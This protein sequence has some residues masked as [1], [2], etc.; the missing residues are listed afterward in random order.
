MELASRQPT[1]PAHRRA[2][3]VFW[4]AWAV[5]LL[6]KLQ[7]ATLDGTIDV[8][9][10]AEW[11]AT[12]ARAGFSA[13]YNS[14]ELYTIT[15][16]AAGYA[17]M[18]HALAGP[19]GIAFGFLLRLPGILAEALFGIVLWRR[20]ASCGGL[21][22]WI[23]AIFVLNPINLAV[24]GYHGNLDGFMAV[25]L[26]AALLAA[27]DDRPVACGLWIA[28]AANLKVAALLV[29]PAFFLCWLARGRARPF[30]AAAAAGM[31]A[32]WSPGLLAG[33]PVF[34]A[35]MLGYGGLWGT[36]GISRL[37]YLSGLPAFHTIQYGLPS[38]PA[39]LVATALKLIVVTLACALAWRRRRLGA[40]GLVGTV[41]ATWTVFYVLAPGGAA[42]YTVWLV[43]PLLLYHARLGLA[44]LAAATPF[45]VIFYPKAFALMLG[46]NP[47]PALVALF[48]SLDFADVFSWTQP[49]LI[50][51]GAVVVLLLYE[52]RR[53][54][55]ARA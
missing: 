52:G 40:V 54:W 19:D 13:A 16:L 42:Q 3:I 10:Y 21:R 28:L 50:L 11:G 45:M 29:G 17:A 15:P 9:T 39:K 55:S 34:L 35:R 27:H 22:R 31:L 1:D 24:T 6:L 48:P 26:G 30:A 25:C 44:Y 51:W 12:L 8:R 43:L 46:F 53:W 14:S 23:P 33:P 5:A 18:L 32:G 49:A 2:P 37:L 36:W 41:A 4:T 7:L 20:L 38:A 47:Y